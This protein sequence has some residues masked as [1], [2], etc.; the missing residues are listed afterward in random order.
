MNTFASGDDFRSF[1]FPSLSKGKSHQSHR[2]SGTLL[3]H[4]DPIL[5]GQPPLIPPLTQ[6]ELAIPMHTGI[7]L[8]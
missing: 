3:A 4:L 1:P 5:L 6:T 8:R 7:N 2:I